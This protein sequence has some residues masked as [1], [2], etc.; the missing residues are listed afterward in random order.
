MRIESSQG[1]VPGD[2]LP[3]ANSGQRAV[4]WHRP[5]TSAADPAETGMTFEL[6]K[7]LFAYASANRHRCL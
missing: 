2:S 6:L 4:L 5:V 7:S 1:A 3:V